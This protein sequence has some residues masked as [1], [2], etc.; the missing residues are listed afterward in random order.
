MCNVINFAEILQKGNS[1]SCFLFLLFSMQFRCAQEMPRVRHFCLS[2]RRP[3]SRFRCKYKSS[4]KFI[5]FSILHIS[6]RMDY[7]ERK[8]MMFVYENVSFFTNLMK[9]NHLNTFLTESS[10]QGPGSKILSFIYLCPWATEP[11]VLL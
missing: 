7:S 5:T 1:S 10:A 3:R 9:A 6:R 2:W 8:R 4:P 11:V